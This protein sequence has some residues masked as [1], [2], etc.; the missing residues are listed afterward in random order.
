MCPFRSHPPGLDFTLEIP[1]AANEG[2]RQ[3]PLLAMCI[4]PETPSLTGGWALD[5]WDGDRRQDATGHLG[6]GAWPADERSER[7]R[8]R[9]LDGMPAAA[10][11]RPPDP[12]E[13][14]KPESRIPGRTATCCL[15]EVDLDKLRLMPR[16]KL[17]AWQLYVL[18]TEYASRF[19][20][21]PDLRDFQLL[22]ILDRARRYG[23]WI[24]TSSDL[25]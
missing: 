25:L 13:G 18:A 3:G 6:P 20:D 2:D 14:N 16:G 22:V 12:A 15:V 5:S 10:R 4:A 1:L 19:R 23:M 9:L 11:R 21:N 24:W 7:E 8:E 17:R